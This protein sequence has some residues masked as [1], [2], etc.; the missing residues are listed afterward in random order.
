MAT[1]P[2]CPH[3]QHFPNPC[4]ACA[5]QNS[6]CVQ[7]VQITGGDGVRTARGAIEMATGFEQRPCLI[8]RHFEKDEQKLIRHLLRNKLTPDENGIFLT[9]I[10]KDFPGRKSMKIDPKTYGWC[11]LDTIVTDMLATCSSFSPARTSSELQS[12]IK[13]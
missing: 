3:E 13:S 5:A 2:E 8:C 11:R 1:C 12:R 7:S 9:P 6:T 10:A 4:S